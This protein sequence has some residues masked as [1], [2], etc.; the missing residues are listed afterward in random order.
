MI[1]KIRAID[2]Y[3][4]LPI[5]VVSYKDRE[6]DKNAALDAGANYYVTKAS[7]DSGEMMN[8]IEMLIGDFV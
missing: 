6:Q 2:K 5:I 4:T 1:A 7:F 3:A 8:Q